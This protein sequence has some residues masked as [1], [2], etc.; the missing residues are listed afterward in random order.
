M[1]IFVT[2]G[3]GYLGGNFIEL[4]L[5]RNHNIFA[6]TRKYQK[7]KKNLKWLKGPF[8][9]NWKELEKADVLIHFAA[10]GVY[11]KTCS[12]KKCIDI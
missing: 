1:K 9:K 7:N 2:G 8:Y 10:E 4:A 5:R 12:L 3:T 11:D 6:T